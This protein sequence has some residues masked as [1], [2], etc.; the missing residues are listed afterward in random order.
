[1]NRAAF[2]RRPR[3]RSARFSRLVLAPLPAD[4]ERC[5]Q[6]PHVPHKTTCKDADHGCCAAEL[7]TEARNG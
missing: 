1:M 3:F 7:S 2:P 5:E 4:G 6:H